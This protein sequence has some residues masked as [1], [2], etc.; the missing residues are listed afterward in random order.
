MHQLNIA[1][2]VAAFVVVTIGLISSRIESLPVSKPLIALGVGIAAGPEVL[3]WLVPENW[4]NPHQV[5]ETAARFT[6]AI[7]VF[8]IALRTPIENY[9]R[10]LR[11]VGLL[12]T[13]GM[14]A[15]WLISAGLAWA[16]LGVSPLLA[17]L[18][19][20]V[21]TPTDPVVASSIVTGGLAGRS[22]PDRLRSTLSLES[23]ANDGLAY[24]I[25]LL[26]ILLLT[27]APP[28]AAWERWVW[29][30]L[31]VGVLSAIVI[32]AVIGF[33]VAKALHRADLA[34]WVEQHSLLGLSV[35]L[36]VFVVTA[37][38]LLGSDGILA[39]FAAGA[40]FNLTIDRSEAYEEQNVQ[41]A[42]GRLFTLPIFILFGAMLPWRAWIDLGWPVL[43]F[44][45]AV[46]LLRRPVTLLVLGGG[47]GASLTHRDAV[48]AG[49]FAP[50]GIA[51]LYYALL[52]VDRTGDQI[53]WTA[54]SLV[55][56]ASVLAHGVTSAPGIAA[57]RRAS[58]NPEPDASS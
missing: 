20:A 27:I 17:L 47:L 52:A 54:A 57:Y 58:D 30:V 37:A 29:E 23:G 33:L 50:I 39:A 8:G 10:L 4:P 32:G 13:V 6:L 40:A 44:A 22:L 18:L 51:A 26:P 11:P 9:R 42:I 5:L 41:E 15:M 7:S 56:V 14:M 45:L 49:W 19:G 36:S 38:K 35:A 12:L 55:I 16:L 24:L 28:S 48:F 25:V 34:G 53:T 2:A 21:L 1:I 43:G 3:G 46:L 31:I